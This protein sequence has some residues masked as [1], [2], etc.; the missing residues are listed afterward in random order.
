MHVMR[1]WSSTYYSFDEAL[2][3][4]VFAGHNIR[5]RVRKVIIIIVII[6]ANTLYFDGFDDS[7]ILHDRYS[8]VHVRRIYYTYDCYSTDADSR[9]DDD[10]VSIYVQR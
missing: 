5:A 2:D 1:K 9:V 10:P 7:L 8:V 6:D 4:Y 3:V